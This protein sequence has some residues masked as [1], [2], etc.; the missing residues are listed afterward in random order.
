MDRPNYYSSPPYVFV[1]ETMDDFALEIHAVVAKF[2][3]Q[4]PLLTHPQRDIRR[5]LPGAESFQFFDLDPLDPAQAP[6]QRVLAMRDAASARNVN[7]N[8]LRSSDPLGFV[9]IVLTAIGAGLASG[10]G[11]DIWR[12]IKQEFANLRGTPGTEPRAMESEP[13]ELRRL[14]DE[15]ASVRSD[16]QPIVLVRLAE[17]NRTFVVE[18]NLPAIAI[19]KAE[20]LV[21]RHN[22][23]SAD[24]T[25]RWSQERNQW[26]AMSD[27]LQTEESLRNVIREINDRLADDQVDGPSQI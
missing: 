4:A 5:F 2:A 11:G 19:T 15:L 1:S 9:L 21:R 6:L 26:L 10:I 25:L 17:A 23:G 8:V 13:S 7:P 3:P 14:F 24:I 18:T 16:I 27:L 20:H 12:A 22:I